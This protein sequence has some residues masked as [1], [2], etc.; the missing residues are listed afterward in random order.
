MKLTSLALLGLL[1]AGAGTGVYATT[2]T[3]V[4]PASETVS[5]ETTSTE[6]NTTEDAKDVINPADVTLSEDQA[7][8]AA[9]DSVAGSIFVAI[10]LED[11]NG[12]I[13]YGVEVQSGTSKLD[14]KVDAN[15]GAILA[16]DQDNESKTGSL[17][18]DSSETDNSATDTDNVQEEVQD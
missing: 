3:T 15:T 16:S 8:Q 18:S 13:V 11:E 2:G 14:V 7:K 1:T 17:E 10:E 4:T 6:T 12:T 9:L 5:A